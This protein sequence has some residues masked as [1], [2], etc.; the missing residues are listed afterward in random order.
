LKL[1]FWVLEAF[2]LLCLLAALF[3]VA[4]AL[5]TD[6]FAEPDTRQNLLSALNFLRYKTYSVKEAKDG[7]PPKP[8]TRREPLYPT[9]LSLWMAAVRQQD[10]IAEP[11][12]LAGLAPEFVRELKSLNVLLHMCLVLASW[13]AA[14]TFF[15]RP[16]PA[17][18]VAAL[19]AFNSSM[20]S[21]IDVFLTEIP[22][23]LFLATSC[24]LLYLSYARRNPAYPILGGL[25]MAALALTKTI[26]F[27]FL[28]LLLVAA[29]IWL[30][31]KAIR[32]DR[33]N[34]SFAVRW[35]ILALVALAAYSP[36]YVRNQR[37]GG[38]LQVDDRGEGVLAIRAEYSTMSW[39][40]Y[41]ASFF[42][43]TPAVG[44]RLASA[45]FGQ[46]VTQGLD[47]D[48]LDGFYRRGMNRTGVVQSRALA[49]KI[50]YSRAAVQI[51]AEHLPMMAMLTLPFAYQGAFVQLGFNVR[52]VARPLVYF[53]AAYSLFF[54]PAFIALAVRL[55]RKKD[56]RWPFPVP[57]LYS[58]LFYSLFT[59]YIPRYSVPLVPIFIIALLSTI[60]TLAGKRQKHEAGRTDT[61]SQ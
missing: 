45:L 44:P 60:L 1:P 18:A 27:Y 37:L 41:A 39:R 16:W 20:L 17:L 2:F 4:M 5:R 42:Y 54:V 30:A 59:H 57:A 48:N 11:P 53:T 31:V 34:R 52:R 23:A 35:A 19:I 40:Q 21:T 12:T 49:K 28:I 36:W 55:G 32:R 33:P 58:Y 7:V 26:Y 25:S 24:A 9:L 13:W 3:P 43:F 22:A 8:T 38:T 46:E 10:S 15:R 56:P 50:S 29:A 47:R 51:M 14:R 61:V 6:Y